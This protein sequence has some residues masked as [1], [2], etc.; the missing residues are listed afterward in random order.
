MTQ[1]FEHSLKKL[2]KNNRRCEIFFRGGGT[3]SFAHDH[4]TGGLR[5]DLETDKKGLITHKTYDHII[6]AIGQKEFN[7]TFGVLLP[8]EMD[9]LNIQK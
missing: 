5:F 2:L 6:N 4:Q 3:L 8:Q 1:N 7:E 9:R